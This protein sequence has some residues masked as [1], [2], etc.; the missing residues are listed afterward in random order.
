MAWS[1]TLRGELA[2][3][4]IW[5]DPDRTNEV[6][7]WENECSWPSIRTR[8]QRA[9]FADVDHKVPPH[10]RHRILETIGELRGRGEYHL[11]NRDHHPNLLNL[12]VNDRT[13]TR[14]DHKDDQKDP[15]A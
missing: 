4:D 9:V 13:Y 11:M 6:D 15:L 3:R 8:S 10:P 12:P 7:T 14:F 5:I 2:L 1:G